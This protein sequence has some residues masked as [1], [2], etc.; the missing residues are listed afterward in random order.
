MNPLAC[1]CRSS[2]S[3]TRKYRNR[4]LLKRIVT[5]YSSRINA[6]FATKNKQVEFSQKRTGR[7][8]AYEL[9]Q[10]QKSKSAR[11][12]ERGS[13]ADSPTATVNR[14]A[15][16][17]FSSRSYNTDR[18]QERRKGFFVAGE[19]FLPY[20]NIIWMGVFRFANL[21]SGEVVGRC[22]LQ[23]PEL[24]F[25]SFESIILGLQS[26]PPYLLSLSRIVAPSI[27]CLVFPLPWSLFLLLRHRCWWKTR[28]RRSSSTHTLDKKKKNALA[29]SLPR[30]SLASIFFSSGFCT[31]QLV[32][33]D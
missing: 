12:V 31:K 17:C 9:L 30:F 25:G 21:C 10:K 29:R 2:N 14:T 23:L 32:W 28:Q 1:Y 13:M 5:L 19:A 27:L 8:E 15:F 16:I 18:F 20:Y 33:C 7:F 22:I 24:W 4:I 6:T 26:F 3:K 11:V